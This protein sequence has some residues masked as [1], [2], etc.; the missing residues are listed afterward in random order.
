[1]NLRIK[2]FGRSGTPAADPAGT[3][4]TL[5]QDISVTLIEATRP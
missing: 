1:M 3:A 5:N 2:A 4:T